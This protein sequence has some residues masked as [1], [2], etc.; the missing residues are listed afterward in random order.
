MFRNAIRTV[1]VLQNI[2]YHLG[3]TFFKKGLQ[4]SHDIFSLL[5]IV[6]YVKKHTMPVVQNSFTFMPHM[7]LTSMRLLIFKTQI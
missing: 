1:Q 5:F 4:E 6:Y 7:D 2:S 3:M